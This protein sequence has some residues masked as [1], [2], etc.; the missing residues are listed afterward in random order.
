MECFTVFEQEIHDFI[1]VVENG[2]GINGKVAIIADGVTLPKPDMVKITSSTAI[3][4]Y[5]PARAQIIKRANFFQYKDS[6]RDKNNTIPVIIDEDV[7]YLPGWAL[8]LWIVKK[9]G[10]YHFDDIPYITAAYS[11]VGPIECLG[12][13]Q[14]LFAMIGGGSDIKVKLKNTALHLHYFHGKLELTKI[15]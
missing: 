1:P 14:Y 11:I 3:H 13:D 6:S 4:P 2:I 8:V 9:D 5:A 15:R 12:Y 7:H 10:P